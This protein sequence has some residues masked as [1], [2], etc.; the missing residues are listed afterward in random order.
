M[1]LV[2]ALRG[3]GATRGQVMREMAAL[4]TAYNEL[5]LAELLTRLASE[6]AVT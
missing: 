6:Q 5:F 3:D 4:A 1:L 2:R